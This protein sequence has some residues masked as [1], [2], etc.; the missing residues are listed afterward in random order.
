[1]ENSDSLNPPVTSSPKV[2]LMDA[3]TS[4]SQGV[5]LKDRLRQYQELKGTKPGS[6]FRKTEQQQELDRL[7]QMSPV[8]R[9]SQKF[10]TADRSSW[11]GPRAPLIDSD[12]EDK[13]TS[14]PAKQAAP[15]ADTTS[16]P[17]DPDGETSWVPSTTSEE[18]ASVEGGGNTA[19]K[20]VE[21]GVE[22]SK[23][24]LPE[25]DEN[26]QSWAPPM[27]SDAA[28]GDPADEEE[29]IVESEFE[30]EE[31]V[32]DE[33][34]VEEE[35]DEEIE[36]EIVEEEY[37]ES[38]RE[39]DDMVEELVDLIEEETVQTSTSNKP[40]DPEEES[41]S[42]V[43]GKQ[44]VFDMIDNDTVTEAGSAAVTSNKP[45]AQSRED[46]IETGRRTRAPP[47]Q[48]RKQ[49]P[50]P[51]QARSRSAPVAA[52]M[53]SA[54]AGD[55]K[56]NSCLSKKQSVCLNVVLTCAIVAILAIMLPLL[57]VN[58]DSEDSDRGGIDPLETPAPTVGGTSGP[59]TPTTPTESP[60]TPPPTVG[61][62]LS[63]TT[64]RMG[65][66]VEEYL[67]PVSG[68]EVFQD[69]S[70]PQYQAALYMADFDDH[71]EEL[72][73]LGELADRYAA[74][75]FYFATGGDDWNACFLGDTSCNEPDNGP[76]LTGDIC[77]WRSVSCNEDG[78]VISIDFGKST[79]YSRMR[80]HIM[81][82][83]YHV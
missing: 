8:Q 38:A 53:G 23:E 35:S 40:R 36:E 69:P 47:P 50:P 80:L 83:P 46:D 33:E 22:E 18:K 79:Q 70:T 54:P 71:I 44:E 73:S 41:V 64:T 49:Q 1:M 55:E 15:T 58:R 24:P 42:V 37:E 27:L 16:E 52:A 78:R 43:A 10:S 72:E 51:E 30:E 45:P 68:E 13:E 11:K 20:V 62:T 67:I 39:D 34:I 17:Q 75:T 74:T 63:P 29:V 66:F 4:V 81:T 6:S 82:S 59:G 77:T 48:K 76:W 28:P 25:E 5:S 12:G 19:A 26:E 3:E 32:E 56:S 65:Q 60:P 61:D 31:V 9:A 57:L 14:T 21:G 7:Q 2:A